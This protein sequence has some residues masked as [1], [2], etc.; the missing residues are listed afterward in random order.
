MRNEEEANQFKRAATRSP[1]TPAVLQYSCELSVQG[2]S[3]QR[4]RG[5]HPMPA[6]KSSDVV[7]LAEWKR[8]SSS[9]ARE[10]ILAF[11]H[12]TLA[13]ERMDCGLHEPMQTLAVP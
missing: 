6:L 11:L 2:L 1:T 12:A 13:W 7:E 8:Y 9:T 4:S 5:L 10:S 3:P